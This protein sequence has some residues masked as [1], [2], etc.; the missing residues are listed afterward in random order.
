MFD[1]MP[2]ALKYFPEE[3]NGLASS[4]VQLSCSGEYR[5]F[6]VSSDQICLSK[7]VVSPPDL[8]VA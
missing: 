4:A 7:D 6:D 3:P 1:P 2:T 5:I 8:A